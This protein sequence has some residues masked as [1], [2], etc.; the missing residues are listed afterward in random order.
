MDMLSDDVL[1]AIFDFYV[2]AP[3]GLF[4]ASKK[5]IEAW[6][7]LVHVC[8]LWRNVVFGSPR[9]LN[10]R[11][12]CTYKTH[13]RNTLDVWPA[14]PL[15]I[16]DFYERPHKSA[17]DILAALGH[18]D[19]IRQVV[20]QHFECWEL[21]EVWAVM[22]VP[23]PEL[24]DL[25]LRAP[26][27]WT[28]VVPDSF[29]GG[30]A[31]LLRNVKLE[32]VPFPGL[33]KLLLSATNLVTLLLLSI[34]DPGY[35]S[36]EAMATCFCAL[37]SLHELVIK[38][39]S[40]HS[41]PDRETRHLSPPKRSVL[42]A[43]TVFEFRGVVKYLEDLVAHIDS[44]RLNNLKI[45]FFHQDHFKTPQLFQLMSRSP[46]LEAPEKA[47]L[48]FQTYLF[49]I[50]L[51]PSQRSGEVRGLWISLTGRHSETEIGRFWP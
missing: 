10:L 35:F 37:T 15:I 8:R 32:R 50:V 23:F 3:D 29:L 18:S 49:R 38:F 42:P 5:E 40:P 36:P 1:L 46:S 39:Q 14:L 12:A 30:S 47:I 41:H 17:D 7:R 2:E 11:L 16:Y 44:P 45:T 22:R 20:M 13:V 6:Q 27:K 9:R 43:L 19:R 33:P 4:L 26:H 31:P 48:T 25:G 21:E 28:P 24:T 34:P 51:L